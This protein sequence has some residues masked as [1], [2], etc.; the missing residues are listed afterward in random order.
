MI[1]LKMLTLTFVRDPFTTLNIVVVCQGQT[2]CV[3]A[4]KRRSNFSS[5]VQMFANTFTLT[6]SLL[7]HFYLIL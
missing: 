5:N 6:F 2:V 4:F 7:A 3:I 1:H